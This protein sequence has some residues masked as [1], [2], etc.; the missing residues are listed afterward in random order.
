MAAL[1]AA[2]AAV[3]GLWQ[4]SISW[5]R[6]WRRGGVGKLCHPWCPHLAGWFVH[7]IVLYVQGKVLPENNNCLT[8]WGMFSFFSYTYIFTISNSYFGTA[9]SFSV[10][11]QFQATH[12]QSVQTC[13]TIQPAVQSVK[14][15]LCRSILGLLF[16]LLSYDDAEPTWEHLKEFKIKCIIQL[17]DTFLHTH[18]NPKVAHCIPDEGIFKWH[19][20]Q[21]SPSS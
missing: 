8:Q 17:Y 7:L 3:V 9:K 1:T 18:N 20:A 5:T 16:L 6:G 10:L 21:H 4:M 13:W 14:V 11:G 15:C 19:N 12:K 2:R